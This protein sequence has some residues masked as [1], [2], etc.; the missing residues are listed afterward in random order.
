LAGADFE[1]GVVDA[2]RFAH[3]EKP[4]EGLARPVLDVDR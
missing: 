1:G 2:G 3:A 4:V